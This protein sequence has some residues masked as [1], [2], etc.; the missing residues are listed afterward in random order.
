MKERPILFS[1]PMVRAILEGRKTQT[2]RVVK[3]QPELSERVGFI[4]KGM[5]YGLGGSYDP[6]GLRNLNCRCPYGQPGDRL[7]VKETHRPGAWREDGRVAFDYAASPELKNTPWR[8]CPDGELFERLTMKWCDA[9][10]RA[11]LEMDD[12]GMYAW[13]AGECPMVWTPSIYMPRWASRITLEIVS[14][15][16]ERLQ[17]ISNPDCY[18]EGVEDIR[19]ANCGFPVPCGPCQ[20]PSP[21]PRTAYLRLWESINGPGSWDINP[22]VWVVEFRRSN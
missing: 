7:W 15:R 22:W 2:R 17:D 1:A 18:A 16:V 19:C 8:Q 10:E 20:N 21:D 6:K 5:A 13:P 14:V 3:P 12:D 9:L 4:Y 11:G